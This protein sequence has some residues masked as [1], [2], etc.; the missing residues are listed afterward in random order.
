MVHV[1]A[2]ISDAVVPE[3]VQIL[4]VTEAKLTAS[5]ELAVASNVNSDPPTWLLI[6][7]NLIVWLAGAKLATLRRTVL[8]TRIL[9]LPPAVRFRTSAGPPTER[10]IRS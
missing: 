4:G 7:G 9:G 5:P 1:P 2:A 8:P 6:A 10:L 3:T